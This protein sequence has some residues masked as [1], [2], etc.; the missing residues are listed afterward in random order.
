VKWASTL[1]VQ[2]RLEAAVHEAT[3][4][5]GDQMGR[6]SPDLLFVFVSAHHAAEYERVGA[7]LRGEFPSALLLGCSAGG[8]IGGAREEE[9]EPAL[10]LTAAHLP[11]VDLLPFHLDTEALPS[12]E[13][14]RDAWYDLLGVGRESAPHFVLLPDPFSFEGEGFLRGLD[15]AYPDAKKFGGLAS[16]GRQP[17]ENA[18]FLGQRVYR[19]GALGV[20][21]SGA[22][23][24]DTIVAQGC[25]TIGSPMFVTR[26]DRNLLSE[27][28]G[29]RPLAVLQELYDGLDEHDR[30]LADHSL[31]LGIAMSGEKQ[32]YRQGDFLV[33]NI[34]GADSDSGAIAIGAIL[35][36]TAVVQF[37]L[38]DAR[39]SADDLDELLARYGR[40]HPDARPAGSLLFSCLGRGRYLYGRADH[41]TG[42]FRS[43]LGDVP[44]GGFFCN[45]EIGPV[46]GTTFLHGYTSAFGLFGSG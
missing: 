42:A 44:I 13:A 9:H 7:L 22:V 8:V 18:L 20:A 11:D 32:E 31:F 30:G 37:H 6:I 35:R 43:H 27:L 23:S 33:R 45:G 25:R 10:S 5:I 3:A 46:R 41:D 40:E 17:G 28:D 36:N 2:P 12:A 19:S 14:S 34:I 15:E 1:S 29:R 24:V 16:G 21:L 38:R 4:S 39:T 26:A